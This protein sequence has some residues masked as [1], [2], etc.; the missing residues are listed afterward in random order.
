MFW[1]VSGSLSSAISRFLNFEM[2]RADMEK[3]QKVFSTSFIIMV[4]L[5]I[6]VII[7]AE[8]IG[9]WFLNNRMTIPEG[10]ETAA[11]WVF[12]FSILTVVS[13]FTVS[14]FN[15]L[16][17]AHEK[18]GVYAYLNIFEAISRLI[19]ALVLA[20]GNL[21]GDRLIWYAALWLFVTL[22]TQM[23]ARVYAMRHFDE[24]KIRWVRDKDLFKELFSY[25]GWNFVDSISGTFSGQGVNM[26]L[27]VVWG[28]AVNASRNLANTIKNT[29]SL[30]VNNFT[31]A[32][33]PQITQSYAAGEKEYMK[34]LLFRGT[35]FSYFILFFITL[36]LLLE[37]DFVTYLWLGE[38]PEHLVSFLQLLLLTN[39][40]TPFFV[41]FN[42]GIH[43][44]GEIRNFKLISSLN[45]FMIFP[46]SYVMMHKGFQPEWV[47]I[48]GIALSVTQASISIYFA[49]KLLG[50]RIRDI[51]T[52]LII[53]SLLVSLCS[54]IIPYLVHQKMEYGWLRL[55]SVCIVSVICTTPSILFLGCDKAERQALIRMIL[56]TLRRVFPSS[57]I[58]SQE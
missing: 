47:Y 9:M 51:I 25:A 14:P 30:L 48:T 55:I 56:K 21:T 42:M 2:G 36:P 53:P 35:K 54:Y 11:F 19:I 29:V 10:R 1:L 15:S 40:L 5:S 33:N 31:L 23:V 16:I 22:L 39:L 26:V 34:T 50:L 7:L 13:G 3:T 43:A 52:Q 20:Y 49:K 6:I 32:V 28:P 27:N 24:C 46:I 12:Q 18:M 41:I 45:S 8:T 37:S 57:S 4:L 58:T 44:T 17:I 38:K